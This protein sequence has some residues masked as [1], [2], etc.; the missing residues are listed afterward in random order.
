MQKGKKGSRVRHATKTE[1]GVGQLLEDANSQSFH[2]F[3]EGAGEKFLTA[4]AADKL[5]WVNGA[6]AQSALLNNLYLPANGKSRPMRTIAE[7]KARLLEIY[8]G[9][10]HGQKMK[11]HERDYKDR[12]SALARQWYSPDGLQSALTE[13]RYAD[14][15][16][17][18][19]Q[20][21]KCSDNNLPA[22]FEKMAFANAV[23]DHSRPKAFAE[24]FCAW[25]LP[26]QPSQEAFDAF[27]QELDHMGCA[28]WP[29][30]TAY[31]FLPH[32]EVDV[33]IKPTNLA[34][35]AEVARFEI[36]YRP[37]LNWLTYSTVMT[38]YGYVKQQIADLQ[39]RDM[40][41]VQNFIWCIDPEYGGMD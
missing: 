14:V 33:L 38:F 22:T 20:L 1:W 9:G 7:A 3:F 13:G 35:A 40:I 34:N 23:K 26:E 4:T 10:L 37:E 32:P 21:V 30:L 18:A 16:Q 19:Y 6:E 31:R 41:D 25:V 2:V 39:P 29:L 17:L 8:P 12:L 11:D 28:K 24:A 5:I 36:N 27:A 15:V